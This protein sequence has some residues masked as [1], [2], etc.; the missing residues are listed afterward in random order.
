MSMDAHFHQVVYR[1]RVKRVP[2]EALLISKKFLPQNLLQTR[3]GEPVKVD[4]D[5]T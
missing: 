3:A 4:S 5:R 1:L 2:T